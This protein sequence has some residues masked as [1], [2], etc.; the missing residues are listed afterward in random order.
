VQ[1][2]FQTMLSM[3]LELEDPPDLQGVTT[4]KHIA[5]TVGFAGVV[6][7]DADDK[8]SGRYFTQQGEELKGFQETSQI[9]VAHSIEEARSAM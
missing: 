2:V 6:A 4:G 5:G 7:E 8:K 3:P 9:T 1:G